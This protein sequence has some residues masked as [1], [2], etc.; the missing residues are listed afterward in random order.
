MNQEESE[1]YFEGTIKKNTAY[2][3]TWIRSVNE[4][5]G[6][7]FRL[8]I[9]MDTHHLISAK[10]VE[11]SK[12][13]PALILKGYNINQ[14]SNLVGFPATLLG[15]CQLH[16]QL[17]RGDHLKGDDEESYHDHISTLL[18]DDDIIKKINDCGKK[19]TPRQRQ[20]PIKEILDEI[21]KNILDS[22]NKWHKEKKRYALP[23]TIISHYFGPEM[24][25]CVDCFDI[26]DA[27]GKNNKCKKNRLH[28][29]SPEHNNTGEDLR[30][31]RSPDD[32]DIKGNLK[33]ITFKKTS[34][35]PKVG[36]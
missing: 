8:G 34:W 17:H 26:N 16:C 29:K 10:S 20:Y 11:I 21:S 14:L 13:G 28:Y 32:K 24:Q 31:Q 9:H 23:L 5:K 19:T 12:R 6:H 15:A 25:G 33:L 36:Q 22:I 30:Y 18:N 3:D 4:I 35:I 7:P 2:R 1:S 27:I